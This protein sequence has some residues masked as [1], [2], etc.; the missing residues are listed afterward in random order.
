M[1]QIKHEGTNLAKLPA[2]QEKADFSKQGASLF[3]GIIQGIEQAQRSME[4]KQKKQT[5]TKPKQKER[6]KQKGIG[7]NELEG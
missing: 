2:M 4:Q 3:D 6:F 5:K 7:E 1:E